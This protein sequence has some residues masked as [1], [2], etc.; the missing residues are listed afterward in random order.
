MAVKFRRNA[1]PKNYPLIPATK[2]V[3]AVLAA[4]PSGIVAGNRQQ[5]PAT[6]IEK[7]GN[8]SYVPPGQQERILHRHFRGES[9]RGISREEH[10]DFRTVAKVIRANPARLKEH[11]ELSRAQFYALTTQALETIRRAMENGDARLAY[12]LLTDTGVVPEPGQIPYPVGPESS[13]APELTAK[14]K[15]IADFVETAMEQAKEYGM[16]VD[17]I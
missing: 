9:I 4:L 7:R 6:S 14:A 1:M 13:E 15:Y 2:V 5:H 3:P 17:P 12:K 16:D 11:L 8:G 10:R